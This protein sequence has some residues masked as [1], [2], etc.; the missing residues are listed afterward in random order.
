MYQINDV[1]IYGAHGVC[2]I[3]G[4]EEKILSGDRRTYFVLKPVRDNGATIFVPTD[5]QLVLQK[6]RKP[7]SVEQTN[8]LIDSMETQEVAWIPDENAR[9]EL[10]KRILAGGDPLELIRMIKAIYQHRQERQAAG[11]RL[12]T[13]DERFFKDAEQILY[14]ELQYVLK[15]NSK[16]EL[17]AYILARTAK[18]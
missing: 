11:R 3:A 8:Q 7:L 2:T 1:I 14:N 9:R 16:E 10:Y 17:L 13:T 18:P 4:I 6:M 5:N 15:L 12:H